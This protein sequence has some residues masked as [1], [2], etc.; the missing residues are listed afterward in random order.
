[1][2]VIRVRLEDKVTENPL[3]DRYRQIALKKSSP[4]WAETGTKL[5]FQQSGPR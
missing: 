3:S 2:R 1:L 5:C 4:G